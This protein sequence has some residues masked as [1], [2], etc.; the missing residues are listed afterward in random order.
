[1]LKKAVNYLLSPQ[2][3]KYAF[4]S[5]SFINFLSRI[6]SYIRMAIIASA[7]GLTAQ[8]DAYNVSHS[9]M[10]ITVFILGNSFDVL[11]IPQLVRALKDKGELYFRR[12]S[13]TLFSFSILST[14]FLIIITYVF[15]KYI[16]RILAPGFDVE[17]RTLTL[18]LLPYF[19]PVA[20]TYIPYYALNTVLKSVKRFR[21]TV[22][23]DFLITLVSLVVVAVYHRKGFYIIPLSL[24]AAYS[25]A[26][27]GEIVCV[28][29]LKLIKF[30]T[31]IFN[32]EMK[33]IY[34][35]MVSLSVLFLI[36]QL[37]RV[38]DKGFGSLLPT[39]NIS[40]LSYA[41][42][43]T[44]LIIT[45]FTFSGIFLTG[46]SETD[47]FDNFFKKSTAMNLLIAIPISTFL[48]LNSTE[49]LGLLF[50]R[51]LFDE[52]ATVFT[53]SLLSI[54]S[55]ILFA[56]LNFNVIHSFFQSQNK[57]KTIIW[58]SSSGLGLNALLNFILIKP[59]AARGIVAATVVSN[60][61]VLVIMIW[62]LY[63]K[64]LK[65]G[66]FVFGL[67]DM[68]LMLIVV[69]PLSILTHILSFN[70]IIKSI[71]FFCTA[72]LILIFFDIP[73]PLGI[74]EMALGL[75][76]KYLQSLRRI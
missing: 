33:T 44:S 64:N 34:H 46:F 74:K 65:R 9:L 38:V 7:F 73:R 18:G 71:L 43:I 11:G 22:T 2:K 23:F 47:N 17:K 58:L 52:K 75:S 28:Y 27:L 31:N 32:P 48:L 61:A 30:T 10:E 39:G 29:K 42:L 66:F 68:L 41:T 57:F 4:I 20:L 3:L 45:M 36:S 19:S 1:M 55:L 40:A 8:M 67:A 12:L 76:R 72:Y 26:L 15:S 59:F 21:I 5:T 35:N 53:G 25:V 51:G 63:G 62:L 70:I 37:Y 24:G 49:V 54:Y 16:I 50:K 60:Y 56:G 13:G 6:N 69:L 14:L